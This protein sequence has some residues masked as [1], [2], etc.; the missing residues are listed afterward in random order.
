[1]WFFGLFMNDKNSQKGYTKALLGAT[2]EI[3]WHM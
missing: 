2:P 1:M 3:D